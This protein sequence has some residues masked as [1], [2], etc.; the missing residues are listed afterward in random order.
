MTDKKKSEKEG[1]QPELQDAA[2]VSGFPF[3]PGG[4]FAQEPA[5][6]APPETPPP[7]PPPPESE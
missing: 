7:P 5:P 3:G 2:L 4:M 6:D 1:E